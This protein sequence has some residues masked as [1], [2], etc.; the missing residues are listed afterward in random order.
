MTGLAAGSAGDRGQGGVSGA[1]PGCDGEGWA[2][3]RSPREPAA[4][5]RHPRERQFRERRFIASQ[6]RADYTLAAGRRPKY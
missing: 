2:A 5:D 1:G 4:G 3:A 6:R